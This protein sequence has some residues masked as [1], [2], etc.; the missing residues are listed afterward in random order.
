MNIVKKTLCIVLALA[1][2]CLSFAG[3][4]GNS[5]TKASDL[6]KVKSAGKI[7]V[8]MECAYAP[9][10]WTQSDDSNGAVPI[11][12]SSDYAY[13]YDVMMAKYICDQLGWELEI[14]KTDWDS[15]IPAIQSGTG[16]VGLCGQSV[17]SDRL[18]LVDFTNWMNAA[19]AVQPLSE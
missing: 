11:K 3:C 2:V 16:D 8:G 4:G 1:F 9:Y 19:I 12:G 13:G 7:T 18:E 6:E 17:T 5:D 15:I 10:N 14:V